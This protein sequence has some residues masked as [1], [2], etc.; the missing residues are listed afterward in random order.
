MHSL[1]VAYSLALLFLCIFR[2]LQQERIHLGLFKPE[3]SK[4]AHADG[5]LLEKLCYA[6]PL[7]LGEFDISFV[8][9]HAFLID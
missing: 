1:M 2:F 7:G 6:R 9:L 3:P 5:K 4:Y 8:R